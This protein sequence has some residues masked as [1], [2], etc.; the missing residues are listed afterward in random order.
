MS[1]Q[2]VASAAPAPARQRALAATLASVAFLVLIIGI[3]YFVILLFTAR[4]GDDAN[5][6]T[7]LWELGQFLTGDMPWYQNTI[8]GTGMPRAIVYCAAS[9]LLALCAI[10]AGSHSLARITLL[11][12]GALTVVLVLWPHELPALILPVTGNV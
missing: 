11:V 1:S 6:A 8:A 10:L 2:S 12:S 9:L 7:A 5:R 3:T 4:Y